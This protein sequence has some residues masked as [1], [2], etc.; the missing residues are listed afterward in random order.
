M[1]KAAVIRAVCFILVTV[2]TLSLVGCRDSVRETRLFKVFDYINGDTFTYEVI[3][4]VGASALEGVAGQYGIQIGEGDVSLLM[5]K[6]R[7]S[8]IVYFLGQRIVFVVD[9]KQYD[10]DYGAK[11]A[12]YTELNQHMFDTL[13][14]RFVV[15]GA[16]STWVELNGAR[17]LNQGQADF[18]G[19][20]RDYEEFRDGKGKVS[21]AFFDENDDLIGL[22]MQQ[23]AGNWVEIP[24]KLS[25]SVPEGIFDIYEDFQHVRNSQ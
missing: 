6:D 11:I 5:Y 7:D 14:G 20:Q 8:L 18:K 23:D 17:M 13:M 3:L 21:R 9:R 1:K 25:N 22:L 15:M 19:V 24:F 12:Y 16:V 2:M 4:D 10:F